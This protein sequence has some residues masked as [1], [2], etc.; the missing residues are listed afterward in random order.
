MI[1]KKTTLLSFS[2]ADALAL[3]KAMSKKAVSPDNINV[4]MNAVKT[5][6]NYAMQTG[7]V[8]HNPTD[9]I[10]PFII[11]RKEKQILTKMEAT[12]VLSILATHS[13]ETQSRKIVY[14][15][16]KLAIFSGM[17]EGEIRAFRTGKMFR[18]IADN[19]EDTDFFKIIIDSAWKEDLQIIGPTKGKYNRTT[20][21]YKTLADELISFALEEKRNDDEIL[22]KASKDRSNRITDENIP[23]AKSL[24][25]KYFNEAVNEI[26]INEEDRKRRGIDFHSLRH[27]YDSE[28]KSVAQNME[29]YTTEIRSAVGHKSKSV[30]ELIYT[31]DTATRLVTLGIMSEHILDIDQE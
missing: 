16:T 30:D 10:K 23:V 1:D 29:L 5:A 26:G 27:F 24:I 31:H 20:V 28:S 4:A 15:A 9:T 12:Q 8:N 13:T 21:I 6:F 18:V 3:Q 17:R 25:Q 19:G 7:V 14:L 22:F 11:V 2:R